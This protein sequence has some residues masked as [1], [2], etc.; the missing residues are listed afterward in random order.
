[1]P[2]A[3]GKPGFKQIHKPL[4]ITPGKLVRPAMRSG[5]FA[6]IRHTIYQDFKRE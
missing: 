5:D 4:L 6:F 3:T 1:M 2:A